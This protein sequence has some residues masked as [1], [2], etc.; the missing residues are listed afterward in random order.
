MPTA[1]CGRDGRYLAVVSVILIATL[2]NCGGG[3]DGTVP[4]VPDPNAIKITT[5]V[6]SEGG[7]AFA[8]SPSWSPD[9]NTVVFTKAVEG[10]SPLGGL[11]RT[12]NVF[13]VSA[14][15]GKQT[16]LSSQTGGADAE[17]PLW[18]PDG[19]SILFSAAK[20]ND[21][22]YQT[23]RDLWVIPATGGTP[24]EV[25]TLPA[26][27]DPLHPDDYYDTLARCWSPD[28]SM[29]LFDSPRRPNAQCCEWRN[30]L[31]PSSGGTPQDVSTTLPG[32]V[33]VGGSWSPDGAQIACTGATSGSDDTDIFIVPV[34]GGTPTPLV[35]TSATEGTPDWSPDGNS[36]AYSSFLN[37]KSSI[38][39]VPAAG[40][41]P[42]KLA[43]FSSVYLIGS[44]WSPDGRYIACSSAPTSDASK[45]WIVPA[46]G[47]TPIKVAE[48]DY[49]HAWHPAW[50]PD[51][52]KIAFVTGSGGIA[53]ASNLPDPSNGR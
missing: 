7:S 30:F 43:E 3:D 37:G 6:S 23:D 39:V 46:G 9:G 53:V 4:V 33:L 44:L 5:L 48:V 49:Q 32:K 18:S 22:F 13:T 16:Q 1:P 31:V 52:K 50:S 2:M 20:S 25:A 38:W 11:R 41:T 10:P 40:G 28:G 21:P 36:I 27:N 42:I 34:A 51:G 14:K 45:L 15:G 17:W 47:G 24:I 35:G 12:D 26:D 8:R 19:A 29:I